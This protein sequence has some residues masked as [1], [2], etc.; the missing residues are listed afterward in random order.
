M[1]ARFFADEPQ[2]K[3]RIQKCIEIA[4]RKKGYLVFRV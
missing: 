2:A 3:I 4:Y 1:Y